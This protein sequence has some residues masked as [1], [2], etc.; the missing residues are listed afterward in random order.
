M[1]EYSFFGVALG[2]LVFLFCGM[3]KSIVGPS[4]RDRTIFDEAIILLLTIIGS[5]AVLYIAYSVA[6]LALYYAKN[7]V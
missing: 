6:R 2:C 7:G 5:A 4:H 1:L 3:F